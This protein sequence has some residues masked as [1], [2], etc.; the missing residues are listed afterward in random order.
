VIRIE[1]ITHGLMCVTGEASM[2]PRLSLCRLLRGST[3]RRSARRAV[4]EAAV[5]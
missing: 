5:Q 2:S 1:W 3:R 4:V